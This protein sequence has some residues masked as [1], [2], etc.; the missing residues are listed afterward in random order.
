MG[1]FVSG[2]VFRGLR[3]G[4]LDNSGATVPAAPPLPAALL[5]LALIGCDGGTKEDSATTPLDTGGLS[6]GDADGDTIIDGH[7][8][9]VDD[10]DGD[11]VPNAFDTD[12]DG[13]GIP[14][15]VEAGDD[16]PR[17][18]PVDSDS[19]GVPDFLDT[20]ADN[21]CVP[22]SAEGT[23]DQDG[24]GRAASADTDDDGD[25]LS[26]VLEIGADCDPPDTDGDGVADYQDR[27]SD[28]DGVADLY[29][30]GATEGEAKD[31]DGDGVPDYQDADSDDDGLTDEEEGGVSSV[32]EAPRDT[33]G[34]GDPDCADI[35]SDGDSLTDD[36]EVASGTD[37]YDPDTDADG[38]SDGAE[39]AAGTDP[40][41][42]T[43]VIDGLYVVLPERS[44]VEQIFTFD[45]TIEMGD[46]AFMLDTTGSMRDTV[47]ALTGEFSTI[48]SRLASVMPDVQYGYGSFNDYAYS[49]FGV[50]GSDR[51]FWLRQQLTDDVR[52]VQ[53]ELTAT[54]A[55]HTGAD[56]PAATMEALYQASTGA[57]YDMDCDGV[58]SVNTDVLPFI[59]SD[60]DPFAGAGGQFYTSTDRS[61]GT[62]GGFG[63]RSYALPIIVYATDEVLRDPD[64]ADTE[65]N[66]T[67]GGCPM[68]AGSTD[69]IAAV[70]AIGAYLIAVSAESEEG[71]PQMRALAEATES[72]ADT[73]DDGLADNPLVFRWYG[74]DAE[75]RETVVGA[76]EDLVS[77]IQF[78]RV[79]LKIEG[80]EWG[81]VTGITPEAYDV[82]GDVVGASVDFTLAFR[83]VVAASTE[84]QLFALTLDVLGDESVLLDQ[85]DI[86]VVVPGSSY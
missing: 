27:D 71:I 51:T 9:G 77:A 8:S 32:E 73:D 78:H 13:D 2:A 62:I 34:D 66:A 82:E 53:S 39:V 50:A 26:D 37:P 81:F 5:A 38:L 25:G 48:V 60:G 67:P 29:E 30:A 49:P 52:E 3:Y 59:A 57:G 79:S 80:D 64:S 14:D 54:E 36:E 72:Y 10:V 46:V 58:Y 83:G 40:L 35:D 43:S 45:L 47:E 56:D 19:D 15:S 85:L 11:G 12:S 16:D 75:F 55:I 61:T 33:D 41:D 70:N 86:I 6:Y 65:I 68:D 28:G 22:D 74:S 7:E 44:D 24:D 84:D 20:D 31:T 69:A 42:E 21:N 17:T 4:V 1:R 23:D 18:L 76:I 63:F